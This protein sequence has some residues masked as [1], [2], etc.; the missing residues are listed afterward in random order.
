MVGRTLAVGEDFAQPP[1]WPD[2]VK[3]VFFDD[4]R[5]ALEGSP[6]G[7]REIEI[8]STGAKAADDKASTSDVNWQEVIEAEVLTTE[9]KRIVFNLAAI[10]KNAAQFQAAKHND[11]RRELTML[12]TL[13]RVIREYPEDVRWQSS[14]AEMERRC[15]QTAES[16][17]VGSAGSLAAVQETHTLLAELL[18]GQAVEVSDMEGE[19][20][21]PE[22]APLMQRMEIALEK[23]LPLLL[24]KDREF[25]KRSL[26]VAHEAQLLAMLSQVIRREEFG[27]ADDETYQNHA[28]GLRESANIVRAAANTQDFVKAVQAA[29][30]ISRSCAN[31]HADY[32]G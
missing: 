9:V 13:F 1:A 12:A 7:D 24:T 5:A 22:F 31:C 25:R 18:R 2:E 26:D 20:G 21:F 32:R 27:F 8:A 17:T 16:C 28:D 4:A 14:A 15:L 11:A 30:A 3:Q 10:N 6:P 29:A 23:N 19:S